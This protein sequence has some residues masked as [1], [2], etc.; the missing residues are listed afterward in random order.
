MTF[1]PA[2]DYPRIGWSSESRSAMGCDSFRDFLEQQ[3]L[4]NSAM[5]WSPSIAAKLEE[6]RAECSEPNWDGEEAQ[7]ISNAVLAVVESVVRSFNITMPRNI[8][9]PDII[10]ENDGEICLSWDLADGRSFSISLGSHGKMNY[11]GQL[12]K[13]GVVHGWQ[14]IDISDPRILREDIEEVARQIIRLYS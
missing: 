13:K 3:S 7:A 8:P 9:A 12:G 14:P 11:A 6:I 10:P 4:S 2:M 1:A 5:D